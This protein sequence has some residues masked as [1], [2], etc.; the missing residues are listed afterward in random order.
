[1]AGMFMD[2]GVEQWNITLGCGHVSDECVHCTAEKLINRLATNPKTPRYHSGFSKVTTFE[3]T[4]REPAHWSAPRQVWVS[5]L[6]DL[7]H[8]D[9]PE[10]FTLQAFRAMAATPYHIYNVQTKRP[11]R[12]KTL[13]NL[14][15][16]DNPDQTQP[17]PRLVQTPDEGLKLL[18]NNEIYGLVTLSDHTFLNY[19]TK[20]QLQ[21]IG[22]Q[23]HNLQKNL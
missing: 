22:Y 5:S 3:D 23:I 1:M 20:K 15:W 21:Y 7:L 11:E 14:T 8:P 6:P 2:A 19:F 16:P 4:L 9:V 10:E 17:E 12:L 13:T 18:K